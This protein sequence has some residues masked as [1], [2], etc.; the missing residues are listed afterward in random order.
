VDDGTQL[1]ELVD[2]VLLLS[3]YPRELEE[4]NDI[5]RGRQLF[6]QAGCVACHTPSLRTGT[7]AV[8]ALS[9]RDV[10]LYSDLLIH[11]LGEHL[12]DYMV[13]GAAGAADW[14]TTPL[15]GLSR[16][17]RY[18]HDG[19]TRDLE[20]VIELHSGEARAARARFRRLPEED[21]HDLLEFL[22]SL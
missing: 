7:H 8:E 14:R 22:K 15:W 18:L 5:R 20:E 1:K 3:P 9:E 17:E 21:K 2:F 16:K 11:D 12:I 19:R 4:S 6:E 13:Q 10:Q